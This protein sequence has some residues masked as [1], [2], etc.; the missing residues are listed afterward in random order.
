MN[1]QLSI[2]QEKFLCALLDAQTSSKNTIK[3]LQRM[4]IVIKENEVDIRKDERLKIA[5]KFSE[6]TIEEITDVETIYN[7]ILKT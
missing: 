2:Q 5:T 3:T 6:L 1:W 7:T 4:Q